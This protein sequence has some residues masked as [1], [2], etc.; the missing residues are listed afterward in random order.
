[1]LAA[2]EAGRQKLDIYYSQT[3]YMKGHVY[4]TATMLAPNSRFQFFLSDD[5]DKERRNAYRKSFE[6]AL[7][8]YQQRLSKDSHEP[9][10]A[11][12]LDKSRGSRLSWMLDEH[13]LPTEPAGD[14]ISQYLDSSKL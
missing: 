9:H 7:V 3:N 1:M 10:S 2:L 4:A 13:M 6:E 14:E 5:W 12:R 8:P 11:A